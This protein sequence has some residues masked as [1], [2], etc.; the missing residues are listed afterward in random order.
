MLCFLFPPLL[1]L[2]LS[3]SPFIMN[4]RSTLKLESDLIRSILP[5]M[6]NLP[7]SDDPGW[8]VFSHDGD[9]VKITLKVLLYLEDTAAVEKEG[10]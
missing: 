4:I 8:V 7:S 2:S 9:V 6:I 3:L 10:L 1:S 5:D